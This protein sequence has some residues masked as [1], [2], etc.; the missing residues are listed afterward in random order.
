MRR[1]LLALSLALP[2]ACAPAAALM[3]P[4]V[5][6]SIGPP[7]PTFSTI[8]YSSTTVTWGAGTNPP[9]TW[10]TV[11]DSTD[12]YSTAISSCSTT[13]LNM[14]FGAGGCGSDL[15]PNTAH[16]YRVMATSGTE[17]SDWVYLGIARTLAA[18]PT[19]FAFTE[20]L[21]SSMT[22]SWAYNNNPNGTLY[23]LW[24]STYSNFSDS[25]RVYP[26]E[27]PRNITGLLQETTYYL[28][29]RAQ[30]YDGVYSD[31]DTPISTTTPYLPPPADLVLSTAAVNISSVTWAWTVTAQ[32]EQYRLKDGSGT[33]VINNLPAGTTF[34]IET[35]LT[36]NTTYTRHA[37]CWNETGSTSSLQVTIHTLAAPPDVP[38]FAYVWMSSATVAWNANGNPSGTLYE[39]WYDSHSDFGEKITIATS[40]VS[41]L[42]SGLNSDTTY[43]VKIRAENWDGLYSV[44]SSTISTLTA[45][46]PPS[47][48][49][50][51]TAAVNISSITWAWTIG[52]A[53]YE[54]YR[55]YTDTA[56]IVVD[57][58]PA[59]TTFWPETGLTPNTTY[60][61]QADCWNASG[62]TQSLALTIRTLANPPASLIFDGVWPSSAALSWSAN[63]NPDG[64]WYEL[65]YST[66]SDFG[67]SI[68]VS[69]GGVYAEIPGLDADTTY[70]ARVRA[71][72]GDGIFSDFSATTSTTTPHPPA[73]LG[74]TL[75]TAAVNPSSITW[76]WQADGASYEHYRIYTD[77]G[78]IVAN[79]LPAGT[80]FWA[81]DPLSVNAPYTRR[82]EC[83]N[84]S[85]SVLS[86]FVTAY[87]AAMPPSAA[88]FSS[89][90]MSSFTFTW[91]GNGNPSGTAYEVW[92]DTHSDFSEKLSISTG[93]APSL[94]TG[95]TPN[96]TYYLKVRAQNHD[97]VYSDFSAAVS[98][99]TVYMPVPANLILSTAAVN[100][101]SATL[102]WQVQALFEQYRVYSDTG[103]LS[104]NLPSGTTYWINAA[105][106]PNTTY[107]RYAE[108]YNAAGSTQSATIT[109]HTLAMPP[110]GF[111][112]DALWSSSAT[113]SWNANGN[114]DGTA[115]EIKYWRLYESTETLTAANT[116][117][118]SIT[119]LLGGMVYMAARAVNWDGTPSD[120]D[121]FISTLVAPTEYQVQPGVETVIHFGRITITIRANT[122][123][124]PA[125]VAVNTPVSVPPGTGKLVALPQPLAVQIESYDQASRAAMQPYGC[126]NISFNYNGLDIGSSDG[127]SLAGA[128][129]DTAHSEWSPFATNKDKTAKTA[130][131]DACHLSVFQLMTGAAESS[132]ANVTVGPNPLRPLRAPGKA[133][134][135]RNL[136]ASANVRIYT[137]TGELLHETNADA[138]GAAVWDGKNR[139]GR[140]VASGV[141][142]A[143][144]TSGSEKKIIKLVII[145]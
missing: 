41:A 129:Y 46:P 122:F 94:T 133:F 13:G 134:T 92:Y 48:L 17:H 39:V 87:T 44:F 104:N 128:Y 11:Q 68:T 9:D 106:A 64:T 65:W 140:Q 110:T 135:F 143:L 101:S 97:G 84:S 12:G 27:S 67:G 102:Q 130:D 145:K 123:L 141:Y 36:P 77:T 86:P 120:Y 61:R 99:L 115:Y 144:I 28:K 111:A 108:C 22:V 76:R 113:V 35:P 117:S 30:N 112:V 38:G 37:E 8:G 142:L 14:L 78:G 42:L 85:G 7:V 6:S 1:T 125:I 95:L 105:L 50:L 5:L 32:F 107:T 100:P 23:D 49:A 29:I 136:T 20:V 57:N 93:A 51:S 124:T 132:L 52:Q 69:T 121:I 2:L 15:T 54:H 79:N 24:Y 80:T 21:P 4:K 139:S 71:Q 83:W 63:T 26:Y 18:P 81:E 72:N 91:S 31:F 55:L 66:A 3:P 88:A 56:G 40:A 74:I 43:Y 89:V 90:W 103:V 59:G 96:A 33:A 131:M 58:L 138:S 45:P 16:A 70:Y 53:K 137:Y 114:P 119:G 19:G 47:G 127:S 116:S 34:W 82:A 73:P 62:S 10:Y 126:L 75:S 118:V 98:T 25:T 109:F 60:T